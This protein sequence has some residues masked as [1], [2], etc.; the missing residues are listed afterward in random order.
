MG[1]S[2]VLAAMPAAS[3]T[4]ILAAKYGGDEVFATKCVVF[5]TLLSMVSAPVWCMVL[6]R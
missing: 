5:T 1:I 2:V 6:Q 4:A 3:T